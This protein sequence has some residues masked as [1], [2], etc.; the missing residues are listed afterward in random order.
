MDWRCAPATATL[1]GL[2]TCAGKIRSSDL[3]F[4]GKAQ[5]I[6]RLQRMV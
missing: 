1:A 3:P 5:G 4:E 2:R 6:S